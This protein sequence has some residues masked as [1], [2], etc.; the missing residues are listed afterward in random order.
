MVE[1]QRGAHSLDL[2][3]VMNFDSRVPDLNVPSILT[4]VCSVSVVIQS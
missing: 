1:L 3:V 4:F 2:E